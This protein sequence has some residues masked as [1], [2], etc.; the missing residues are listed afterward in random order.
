[1]MIDARHYTVV[2][3]GCR[4]GPGGAQLFTPEAPPAPPPAARE[5]TPNRGVREAVLMRLQ[6]GPA[7]MRELVEVTGY[8]MDRV[9]ATLCGLRKVGLVIVAGERIREDAGAYG[10]RLEAVYALAGRSRDGNGHA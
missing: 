9:N 8:S 7:T 3:D 5:R 2:W 4:N 10:R 6:L 1:M